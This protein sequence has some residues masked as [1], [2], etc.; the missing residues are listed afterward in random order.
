M[1]PHPVTLIITNS[2]DY[3]VDLLVSRLGSENVFRFN[4]DL[5]KDYKL[6]VTD[7]TIEIEDPTGRHV[8]DTDIAKVYRRSAMRASTIFPHLELSDGER[9]AEEEVWVALSDIVNIFWEQGKVV[10]IQPLSTMRTAKMQQL[11][12]AA[13]YFEA[14]PYRFVVGHE[15][16]LHKGRKSVAKSFTFKFADGIGFYTRKV[17]EGDL[18]PSHPWFLTDFVDADQDVTVALVRDELFAFALDREPFIDDTIDW[19]KA[20]TEYAHRGWDP[21]SLPENLKRAIFSFAEAVSVHYARL[22]F[23]KKGSRYIF[24]EANYTGEWGWLDPDGEHGLM[25]KI[26][27]EIDPRTP[28]IGCP[29]PR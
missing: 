2:I 17:D 18:D 9:Y 26:L 27:Y 19:R 12:I 21:I 22:D 5:W 29:R 14:T 10:L 1:S 7:S 15:D 24:L 8:T 4:T 13:K 23:L 11:R 6:L 16:Y 25:K 3:V 28:C 20:P